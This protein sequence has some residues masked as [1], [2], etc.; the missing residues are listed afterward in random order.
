[1]SELDRDFTVHSMHGYFGM[2][3]NLFLR[4]TLCLEYLSSGLNLAG[5]AD[6]VIIPSN[7]IFY[8][9]VRVPCKRRVMGW[10]F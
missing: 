3:L 6:F 4:V 10:H 9:Y 1:M 2:R 5:C 8:K 7:V